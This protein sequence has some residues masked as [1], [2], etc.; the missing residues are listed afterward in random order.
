[1]RYGKNF[2][3]I[4]KETIK[5]QLK[6]ISNPV[7][8]KNAFMYNLGSN[9]IKHKYGKVPSVKNFRYLLVNPILPSDLI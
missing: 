6:K 5:N 2:E 7:Y 9:I 3:I 8:S 1:M 4:N